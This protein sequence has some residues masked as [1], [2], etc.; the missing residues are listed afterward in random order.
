M[1][2]ATSHKSIV[3]IICTL[4]LSITFQPVFACHGTGLGNASSSYNLLT[5]Q[6]AVE[7]EFCLGVTDLFGLPSDF[8]ISFEGAPMAPT[9]SPASTT[10][11]ATYEFNEDAFWAGIYC[12]CDDATIGIP[13]TILPNTD[14][15]T[16]SVNGGT[17]SYVVSRSDARL[18]QEC[19]IDCVDESPIG[20]SGGD[21]NYMTDI[22]ACFVITALFPG[23]VEGLIS[24]V[25]MTGAENGVCDSDDEMTLS[26]NGA[27]AVELGQFDAI[28]K[29]NSVAINWTTISEHDVYKYVIERSKDGISQFEEIGNVGVFGNSQARKNYSF[30]DMAPIAKGYYRLK[31]IDIN[32]LMSYTGVISVE[33]EVADIRVINIYP[34]PIIG[35]TEIIYETKAISDVHFK[36]FDVNGTLKADEILSAVNGF[37]IIPFDFTGLREG[38]YFIM[39]ESG[40]EKIVKRVT[41]F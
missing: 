13:P 6:T 39:L 18:T 4:F 20:I 16:A 34:N 21:V 26:L 31:T 25:T 27:L 15:W 10:L 30:E 23:D 1:N 2:N 24:S 11:S 3:I 40:K 19:Q 33:R 22:S 29:E 5:N 7:V 36:V 9:L 35:E 17:I 38:I 28:S 8:E 41:K 37:N 14:T 32:G 12:N